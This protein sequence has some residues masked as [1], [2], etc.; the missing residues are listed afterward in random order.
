MKKSTAK[1]VAWYKH[2]K[3]SKP[4]PIYGRLGFGK[5]K[6]YA[7][8]YENPKDILFKFK[9]GEDNIVIDRYVSTSYGMSKKKT[10][11]PLYIEQYEYDTKQIL[12]MILKGKFYEIYSLDASSRKEIVKMLIK[13]AVVRRLTK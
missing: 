4:I 6:R 7:Y 13:E 9:E 3:Q 11:I 5:H 1:V 8:V 10:T 12:E 2:H